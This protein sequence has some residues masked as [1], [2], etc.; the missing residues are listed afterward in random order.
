MNII[1]T[2][3]SFFHLE[4]QILC[5]QIIKLFDFKKLTYVTKGSLNY[6]VNNRKEC[7]NF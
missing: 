1:Y 2:N 5:C 6:Y 3:Y 7:F 4:E